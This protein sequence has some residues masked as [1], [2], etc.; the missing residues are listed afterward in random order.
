VQRCSRATVVDETCDVTQTRC[1][2]G[3]CEM[4]IPRCGDHENGLSEVMRQRLWRISFGDGRQL[5]R[6]VQATHSKFDLGLGSM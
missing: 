6:L 4:F 5:A 3:V 2:L 1:V